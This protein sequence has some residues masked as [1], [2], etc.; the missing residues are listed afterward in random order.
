M[1]EATLNSSEEMVLGWALLACMFRALV[2][3]VDVRLARS[4]ASSGH[5]RPPSGLDEDGDPILA[6]PDGQVWRER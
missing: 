3:G 5:Q 6:G 4:R 2:S 1:L